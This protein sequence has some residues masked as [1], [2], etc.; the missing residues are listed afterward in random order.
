[1]ERRAAAAAGASWANEIPWR[2]FDQA[3]VPRPTAPELVRPNRALAFMPSREG[4]ATRVLPNDTAVVDMR[5]L[6]ARLQDAARRA[7]VVVFDHARIH[8]V[9]LRSGR[10]R[11]LRIVV[12]DA[13]LELRAALFVDASGTSRTLAKRVPALAAA[14]ADLCSADRCHAAQQTCALADAEAGLRFLRA[15]GVEP[16]VMMVWTGLSGPFSSVMITVEADLSSVDLVSGITQDQRGADALTLLADLRARHPWIGPVLRSGEGVIPVRRPWARLAGGGVA[17][18]GD[19]ACMAFPM[20]GSGVGAGMVAARVLADAVARRAD[21]GDPTALAAYD[22]G[23]QRE[24]GVAHGV[25]DLMRGWAQ[26]L[27]PGEQEL[28]WSSGLL[29]AAALEAGHEQRLPRPSLRLLAHALRGALRAPR[30]AMGLAPVALRVPA[31][32]GLHRLGVRGRA[33]GERL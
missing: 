17:L 5:R 23:A 12:G 22:R 19:A 3:G 33:L 7:G 18:L 16:G 32:L 10:L 4:P 14:S 24:V 28:L 6:V 11:S 26:G 29:P 13:R 2:L 21:P 1:M 8:S 27:D 30:L 31:L 9:A 25:Y 15:S 20:H